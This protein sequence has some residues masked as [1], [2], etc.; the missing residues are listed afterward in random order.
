MAVEVVA[1]ES[2]NFAFIGE[3][4]YPPSLLAAYTILINVPLGLI[5]SIRHE[6]HGQ[7]QPFVR[8]N[9]DR[10]GSAWRHL[11]SRFRAEPTQGSDEYVFIDRLDMRPKHL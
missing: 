5:L 6:H 8:K 9:H 1:S 2:K 11:A 4:L 10:V 7:R 3:R